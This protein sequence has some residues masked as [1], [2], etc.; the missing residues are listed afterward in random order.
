MRPKSIAGLIFFC[1]TLYDEWA[2]GIAA[3]PTLSNES[4]ATQ[5]LVAVGRRNPILAF[6][7]SSKPPDDT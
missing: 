1:G 7:L 6:S 2:P 3:N 5:K 4:W